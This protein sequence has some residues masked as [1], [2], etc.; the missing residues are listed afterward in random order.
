MKKTKISFFFGPGGVGK[1]SLSASLASFYQDKEIKTLIISI[2][3]SL[4]LKQL[5]SLPSTL[6]EF[7]L[8][9]NIQSYPH[10][11][12]FLMDGAWVVKNIINSKD[13]PFNIEKLKLLN[14]ITQ[15]LGGLN[16][17]LAYLT[18]Y[19][20]YQSNKYER[21]II[22][23]APGGHFLDFFQSVNRIESFFEEKLIKI[24][25]RVISKN[26]K[27]NFF[28]KIIDHSMHKLFHYLEVLAGNTFVVD[29]IESI[30]AVYG[31]KDQFRKTLE[32]NAIL[33]NPEI[34]QYYLVA[35]PERSNEK[36][37]I[38]LQNEI[39][40]RV[41]FSPT[42]IL[43]Q[44][45]TNLINKDLQDSYWQQNQD[46]ITRWKNYLAQ[47][48]KREIALTAALFPNFKQIIQIPLLPISNIET[49]LRS[50]HPY[51]GQHEF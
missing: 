49:T 32:L 15:R 12:L 9:N 42:L 3:P 51:W 46:D 8:I 37:I 48:T 16:E 23:T 14:V 43:N 41:G 2:D 30:M 27:N 50:F 25:D 5:F 44:S 20:F 45:A 10:L 29:F 28:S 26:S 31:L 34:T 19:H 17:I 21:I 36:Y 35:T 4:R 38:G 11:D 33:K 6:Q 13:L 40:S 39:Q 7:G 22:D 47:L 1:S 18:L 24:F